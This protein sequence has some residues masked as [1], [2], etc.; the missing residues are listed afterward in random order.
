MD[1]A[2]PAHLQHVGALEAEQ[3][4]FRAG[5]LISHGVGQAAHVGGQHDIVF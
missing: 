5:Q 3:R 4:H 1:Q 2:F